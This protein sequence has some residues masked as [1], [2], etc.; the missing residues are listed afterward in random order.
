MV[1]TGPEIQRQVEEGLIEIDPFN[2]DQINPNSYDVTLS[3]EYE[4]YSRTGV[5]DIRDKESL[6]T[7]KRV[8][9]EQGMRIFPGEGILGI[10]V[11]RTYSP[12]HVPIIF[13]KSSLGRI[14]LTVHQ[15]AGFGDTSFNGRWVLEIV[16]MCNPVIL[17]PGMRIGQIAFI[18]A[19][20]DRKPY[21]GKYQNQFGI[22]PAKVD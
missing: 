7:C 8:I 18:E 13:G 14:F 21:A 19:K 20:G 2:P 9:P 12:N 11:E 15:T 1:L 22:I 3:K 6:K 16:S 4:F 10:T 17:Y 5:L